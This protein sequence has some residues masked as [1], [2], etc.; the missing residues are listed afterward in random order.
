MNIICG[1][2]FIREENVTLK[3]EGTFKFG[4]NVR[5]CAGAVIHSGVIIGNHVLIGDGACIREGV[6]I[7]D[8]TVVGAHSIVENNT[9]IGSNVR[10]Q[11]NAYITAYCKIEDFVFIA[12]C[13]Q[14]SN[15][16]LMARTP[17][18]FTKQN[19]CT[20]KRG[21]RIGVGTTI[22]PNITVGE[23]SFVA[24]GSLLTRDVPPRMYTKGR[25]AKPYKPVPKEE[26]I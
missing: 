17:E 18:Q 16:N 5:L 7:G 12:P 26:W 11:A 15:D 2:T 21:A 9:T 19:G 4:D 23:N 10:I 24:A 13:V 3:G 25:P 8:K 6:V 20:I 1:K 14:T 22:L